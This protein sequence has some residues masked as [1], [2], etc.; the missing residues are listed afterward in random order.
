MTREPSDCKPFISDLRT[1]GLQNLLTRE[2]SPSVICHLPLFVAV[3]VYSP[4]FSSPATGIASIGKAFC[5]H[6]WFLP[7]F[8]SCFLI[9]VSFTDGIGPCTGS[10]GSRS[11]LSLSTFSSYDLTISMDYFYLALISSTSVRIDPDRCRKCCN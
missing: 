9:P 7:I 10:V 1:F 8:D 3:Y 11:S 4:G 6:A 2:Q 5:P